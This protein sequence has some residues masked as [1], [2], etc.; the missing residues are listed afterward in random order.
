M[1]WDRRDWFDGEDDPPLPVTL[2]WPA[3]EAVDALGDKVDATTVGA[4][5]VLVE[6][7]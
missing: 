7:G 2:P 4:T 6:I 5:P 3:S 1:I